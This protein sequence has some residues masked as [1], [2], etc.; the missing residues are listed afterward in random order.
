MTS[1]DIESD[2]A[3]EELIS[4]CEKWRRIYTYA[5]KPPMDEPLWEDGRLNLRAGYPY[6]G[7]TAYIIESKGGGYDVLK[8]TTE[9]RNEPLES[10]R[11]FFT[12]I[13]DAGKYIV[14][15]IGDSLRIDCRIDPIYWAWEDSGLDPRVTQTSLGEYVS[16]FELKEDPNRY[17]VLQAGGIQPENRL[18]PL[19]YDELDGLLL[20]GMP[21]SVL[22]RLGD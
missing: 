12:C 7:W 17:F 13:D 2:P 18:L 16:K 10:L 21:E 19:T 8:S 1:G 9:R 3:V 20:D 6:P 11:A 22:S 14:L 4:R 15:N 5:G